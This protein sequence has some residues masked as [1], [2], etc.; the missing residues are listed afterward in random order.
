MEFLHRRI[1][2]SFA[3][4]VVLLLS[5]TALAIP[6]GQFDLVGTVRFDSDEIDWSPADGGTG[7]AAV[8]A[9]VSGAF[10]G[11]DGTSAT[12]KDL[13]LDVQTPGVPFLPADFLTFVTAPTLS[14]DLTFIEPGQFSSAPCG[15]APAAGQTCT[16][17]TGSP[18][19]LVNLPSGSGLSSIVSFV[20]RGTASD[21]VSDGP[22]TAVYTA[23]FVGL[24][25]Q[26]VL[27]TLGSV[28]SLTTS[29]SGS[30]EVV[31]EPGTLALVSAG[32]G[33]L[34]LRRRRRT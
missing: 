19:N 5:Q 23:Q 10:L 6:I 25:Y 14:L 8:I 34:A 30:F 18:F 15:D 24:S 22:F 26:S 31:P 12:A 1:A 13:D 4:A 9:P 21:G 7:S 20:V 29:Y 11:L 3:V 33:L 28:G 32:L 2:C 17:S 27:A 16:P